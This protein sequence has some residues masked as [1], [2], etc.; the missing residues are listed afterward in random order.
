MHST[1]LLSHTYIPAKPYHIK[2][3]KG[4][5]SYDTHKNV[6]TDARLILIS[7][8]PFGRVIKK[9]VTLEANSQTIS[10]AS[11]KQT[12]NRRRLQLLHGQKRNGYRKL[13]STAHRF[14]LLRTGLLFLGSSNV[15]WVLP[16]IRRHFHIFSL[17]TVPPPLPTHTPLPPCR[18][19][20]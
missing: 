4:H 12:D 18:R 10:S 3:L 7:S 17:S 19:Y 2:N 20:T 8:E 1:C 6:F 5:R 16:L 11:Y 15:A 14:F 9:D 13:K